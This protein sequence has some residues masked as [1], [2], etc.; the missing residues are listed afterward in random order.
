MYI[1]QL[2]VHDIFYIA[3]GILLFLFMGCI[4]YLMDREHNR[5]IRE[6]RRRGDT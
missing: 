2:T 3:L 6:E 5:S 1:V 4:G